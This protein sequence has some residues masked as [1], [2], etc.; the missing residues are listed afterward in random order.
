ML[1]LNNITQNILF[2]GEHSSVPLLQ[3]EHLKHLP[4]FSW[5]P[6]GGAQQYDGKKRLTLQYTYMMDSLLDTNPRR[7]VLNIHPV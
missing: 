4:S 5:S 7:S 3:P 6:F 1:K 2:V